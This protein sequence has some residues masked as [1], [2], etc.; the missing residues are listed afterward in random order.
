MRSRAISRA[1]VIAP[2]P[3][4]ET[5]ATWG[6]LRHLQSQGVALTVI[7]VSDGGAS[8]PGSKTWP[9]SRIAKKRRRETLT[10]LGRLSIRR[11]AVRFLS[12][13]D[14]AVQAH[15]GAVSRCIRRAVRCH[16]PQLVVGPL[17]CDHHPDHSATARAWQRRCA[18][19]TRLGYQV[20]PENAA[21][22][23]CAWRVQLRAKD[24]LAKRWAM[25][26]YRTQSGLIQDCPTGFT[27]SHRLLRA[28]AGPQERFAVLA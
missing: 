1:L 11:R 18:G 10:V 19:E 9:P 20:W 7:V 28:F 8:H 24:V 25:R 14:G 21:P 27:L 17:L 5:I 4:D 26:S 15:E 12:F 16:R 3:D 6:L 23:C 2:H 13:P 22:R